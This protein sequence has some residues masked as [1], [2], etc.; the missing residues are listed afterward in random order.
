VDLVEGPASDQSALANI[1]R[2]IVGLHKEFYGRGP[3]RAKTYFADDLVVVLMRGGFSKAEETLLQEGRGDSVIR[4][5]MDF[6]DVM[7]ARFI[8][9]I[10]DALGR[11]V[12]GM[13]SAS[14]QGPD[15]LCQT[16]ILEPDEGELLADA[17]AGDGD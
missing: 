14:H 12:A 8:G 15:L 11:K 3:T 1:S 9:V 13:M 17:H 16:F 6:Q 4:Q 5:R 10:E 2:R 7:Q